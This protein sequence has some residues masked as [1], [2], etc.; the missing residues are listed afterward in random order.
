MIQ[1]V[2][3]AAIRVVLGKT[4]DPLINQQVQRLAYW[5]AS[6]PL[7]GL[8]EAVPGYA[9]LLV[10]YDPAWLVYEDA[11]EHIQQAIQTSDTVS[12]PP[13]RRIEIPVRYGSQEGPDLAAVAKLHQL[14]E[15]EVIQLHCGKEYRVY[16]MGFT[17]GFAYLGELHPAIVT[18]RL[19]TPR[20]H[21]PAGSVGI[22]GAQTGVYPLESPGGWWII[23][24]TQ[25]KLFDSQR[26][27][28]ALLQPGDTV[29]FTV[30]SEND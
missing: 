11:L 18:P 28:P 30:L 15:D 27:P 7:D 25:M 6:H 20:T 16:L 8:G 21:V 29:R 23:G 2:G 1:P 10:H 5:L 14:S 9:T 12:L 13:G 4:M 22:A 3:E 17:P 19:A 24:R 26:E